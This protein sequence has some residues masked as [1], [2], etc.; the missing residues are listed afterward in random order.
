MQRRQFVRYAA[1][2]AAA[3][4]A[5]LLPSATWAQGGT[6]P[7]REQS[8]GAWK[9]R[10]RGML[11]RG[12]LPIID[13]QATYIDATSPGVPPK[14]AQGIG[15]TD[16]SRMMDDMNELDV[17][18]IA[19]A[20]AYAATGEPS[21]KLHRA[22]PEYFIPTTNSGE[23]PRWWRGPE[24]FVAGVAEDLKSGQYFFMGE[25]E[26]RHYPSPE[27][28]RSGRSERDVSIDID[29]AAGRALFE[30]S[31]Q[32]GIA[33]Q[34]HYEIED[35]LL[36]ALESMLARYPKA[37]VIWCHLGQIRYPDRVKNYGPDYVGSLI[38]RF[39]GLHFDLA[40]SAPGQVYQPSGARDATLFNI[41][42]RLEDRWKALLEKYPERFLAA[43]DYRPAVASHYPEMIRRQR[44][45]LLAP[46]S[47]KARHLVAYANAWRLITGNSWSS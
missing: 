9:R 32:S 28:V 47:D 17:A 16:V 35:R 30:L 33:F 27:Q 13:L 4:A 45:L 8:A 31:E 12:R 19:F 23:F 11:D 26:F 6:S 40:V 18:Q 1:G 43:S 39:P 15:T 7:A 37:R 29:S 10:I 38:E 41:W 20:P 24:A 46:L 25:H 5:T 34:I 42:G 2:L 21:L 44:D 36:P 3:C 22:H 14:V